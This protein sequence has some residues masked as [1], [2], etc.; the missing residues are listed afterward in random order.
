MAILKTTDQVADFFNVSTRTVR[1]WHKLGCPKLRRGKF[2]LKAVLGWWIN[3][4]FSVKKSN[5]S[6]KKQISIE[7]KTNDLKGQINQHIDSSREIKSTELS[8][9][10]VISANDVLSAIVKQIKSA[11]MFP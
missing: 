6:C 1:R 2:D 4:I 3:N 11:Q 8:G 10:L 7:R 9:R 5:C